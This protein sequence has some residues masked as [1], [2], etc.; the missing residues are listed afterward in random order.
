MELTKLDGEQEYLFQDEIRSSPW[1]AEFILNEGGAPD[2]D[3]P[4]FDYRGAWLDGE[5][6]KV[7]KNDG[8][9]HWGSKWKSK[10]HATAWKNDFMNEFGYDPDEKGI[11]KEEY[12]SGYVDF[13]K[14]AK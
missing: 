2:L 13:G 12:K 7:N 14:V 8:R 5:T 4:D 10:D 3:Y 11:K 9:L 1:Y 6:L